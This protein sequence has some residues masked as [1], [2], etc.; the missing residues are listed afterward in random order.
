MHRLSCCVQNNAWGKYGSESVVAILAQQSHGYTIDEALP[1]AEL[2]MGAH[3]K[4]PSTLK[5]GNDDIEFGRWIL[6]NPNSLGQHVHDKYKGCFPFLFKVLSI[7]K[8]LALQA[9]PA[10]EHAKNLHKHHPELYLDPNHKPEIAIAL[11]KFEGLCAFRPIKEVLFYLK[12]VPELRILI[13]DEAL[14]MLDTE[15]SLGN[16]KQESMKKALKCCF[17]S[18]MKSDSTIVE[19]QI[20]LLVQKVKRSHAIGEDTSSCLGRLLLHVHEQ[21]PGDVGCFAIYFLNYIQLDPFESIY[22]APNVPHA[23]ISGDIVECLASSD[24]VVRAAFSSKVKDVDTF[25]NMLDYTPRT[26]SDTKLEAVPDKLDEFLYLYDPPCEEFSVRKILIPAGHNMMYTLSSVAGPSIL[27]A[28]SGGAEIN[29]QNKTLNLKI[30][31]VVFI[32]TD[33]ALTLSNFSENEDNLFFQA[34]CSS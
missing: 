31:K 23:Y 27:L 19:M 26:V 3:P 2:W 22:I 13:S 5:N 15:A 14:H 17:E 25:C 16:S 18:L 32:S 21:Y 20:N 1:Y 33:L 34:Y 4:H 8:T 28:L 11:S 9:H 6:Q 12:M 30:G 10:Q 24:N 7:N 29:C